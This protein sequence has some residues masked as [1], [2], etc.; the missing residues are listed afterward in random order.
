MPKLIQLNT[1]GL[2]AQELGTS[3]QRVDY[4]I[5][6]RDDMS[7]WACQLSRGWLG[8]GSR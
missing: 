5:R 2:I 6:T 8:R 3:T 4:V 7:P 1:I